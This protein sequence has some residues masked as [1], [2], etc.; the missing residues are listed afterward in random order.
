[1]SKNADMYVCRQCHTFRFLAHSS[2][3]EDWCTCSEVGAS[4]NSSRGGGYT[5]RVAAGQGKWAVFQSR[6]KVNCKEVESQDTQA[7][8]YIHVHTHSHN[9]FIMHKSLWSTTALKSG[10]VI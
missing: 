2:L 3:Q 1:M 6:E 8:M 7:Y 10:F 5:A 9:N 4:L